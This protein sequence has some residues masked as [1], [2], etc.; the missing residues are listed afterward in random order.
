MARLWKTPQKTAKPLISPQEAYF[1]EGLRIV[2]QL[3]NK[4][5]Q[6]WQI[7]MRLDEAL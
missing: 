4:T 3:R 1:F 2:P 6:K 5:N 7:E